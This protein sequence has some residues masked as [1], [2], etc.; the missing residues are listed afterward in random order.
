MD[1][2][3]HHF[4]ILSQRCDC[5]I[6][7]ADYMSAKKQEP[8]PVYRANIG[9]DISIVVHEAVVIS[10][11]GV[12]IVAMSRRDAITLWREIHNGLN[13]SKAKR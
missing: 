11:L 1:S 12:G 13:Y 6:G 10:Q 9:K 2:K 7:R 4:E 5:G 8:C 3:G